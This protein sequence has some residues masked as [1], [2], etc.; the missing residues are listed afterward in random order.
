MAETKIALLRGINVGKA[1]RVAMADLRKLVAELGYSDVQTLLN[2]GNIVF[3]GKGTN[4]M[5]AKAIEEGIAERLSVSAAVTVISAQELA[6]SLAE[7]P[8]LDLADNPSRL[9]VAVTST[10]KDAARLAPLTKRDW[11]PEAFAL[12]SRV[13]YLWCPDGVIKSTLSAAVNK[14]LGAAVTARNWN[15]TTKLLALAESLETS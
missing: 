3:R 12:G 10:A 7:N 2:S 4:E 14:E 6:R 15:T 5:V 8:L 11:S 13:A 9:L 1:K